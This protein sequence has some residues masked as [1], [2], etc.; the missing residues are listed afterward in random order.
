ME[1]VSALRREAPGGEMGG[2]PGAFGLDRNSSVV[3]ANLGAAWYE[4]GLETI[5]EGHH[6]D[7]VGMRSMRVI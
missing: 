4:P 1:S 5:L 6:G 3:V 2:R 7:A